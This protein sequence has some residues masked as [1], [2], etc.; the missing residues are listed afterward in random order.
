MARNEAY[1]KYQL[2][3]NNPKEHS[4]T[5]DV[6]KTTLSTF[7]SLIYWCICDEVG[8][9]GTYHTH[10]YVAFKNAVMFSTIHQRFYG[11]HIEIAKGSHRENR[12]YIRKEGKWLDNEKHETTVEGTFEEFGDIPE[13]R[14]AKQIQSEAIYDMLK[15]GAS[16]LE[17]VEAFPSALTKIPHIDNM[18]QILLMEEQKERWRDLEVYY[19]WGETSVGKTRYVMEKYG[20]SN[21]YRVTDY[22]HPFDF[23]NNQDVVL[24]EEFQSSLPITQMLT[25]L[26]GYPVSLSARY[27]NKIAVFTK[28]FIATNIPFEEQYPNVQIENI[29]TFNAFK[30]RFTAITEMKRSDFTDEE[31]E[32][33]FDDDFV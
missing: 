28:V 27:A 6:I 4:F 18:R 22:A 7:P 20:Y 23:Y 13:E 17:I 14:P 32:R 2:T 31:I 24:F 5:H 26:D 16:N 10:L 19:I 9:E 15:N 12:D 30:R 25:Y 33:V 21:V 1:R 8:K 11:A 3:F 29:N